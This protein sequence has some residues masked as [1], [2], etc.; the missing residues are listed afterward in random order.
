LNQVNDVKIK[1][2]NGNYQQAYLF[3]VEMYNEDG[4]EIA[5][6]QLT[7]LKQNVD[8]P[9]PNQPGIWESINYPLHVQSTNL[10]NYKNATLKIIN[11]SSK[12][13]QYLAF[14][15]KLLYTFKNSSQLH[16]WPGLDTYTPTY[17][18]MKEGDSIVI[19]NVSFDN[20]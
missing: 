6:Q 12:Q 14:Q 9:D 1:F 10:K 13:G 3:D 19:K 7:Y 15:V 4:D 11:R 16:G 18:A 20:P 8:K 5:Y 2:N 17:K